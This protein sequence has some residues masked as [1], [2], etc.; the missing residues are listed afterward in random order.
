MYSTVYL[1]SVR[2]H[3]EQAPEESTTKEI[4]DTVLEA[5]NKA[6]VGAGSFMSEEQ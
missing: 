2:L 6:Y 3:A 5:A 4:P 1:T